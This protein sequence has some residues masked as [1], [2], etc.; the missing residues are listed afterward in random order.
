MICTYQTSQCD[1]LQP[2]CSR[3]AR[4]L[5]PCSGAGVRRYIFVDHSA[6]EGKTKQSKQSVCRSTFEQN[7]QQVIS[8][9]PPNYQES[10]TAMMVNKLSIKDLRYDVAWAFGPFVSEIPKRLGRSVA[11][12]SAARTF[13]LSLPPGPHTRRHPGSDILESFA[14]ALR[15]TRLALAH[16]VKSKSTDTLCA[17]YLLMICQVSQYCICITRRRWL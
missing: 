4:L 7:Q 15:A 12:D 16:P 3:C 6:P 11:L 14:T 17:A 5:I 8:N 9:I 10:M 1:Q 13:V 2:S